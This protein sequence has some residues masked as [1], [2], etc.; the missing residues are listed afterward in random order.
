MLTGES[1]SIH[2]DIGY[3]VYGGSI[4]AQGTIIIKV[5]RTSENSSINQIIKLVENAQNSRAPIQG[6]ADRISKYFVPMVIL[7]SV[8]AWIIWFSYTYSRKGY[9]NIDLHGMSR[10]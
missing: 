4:L 3:K 5:L 7:L 1:K 8:I 9:D 6:F 2:K 10:F